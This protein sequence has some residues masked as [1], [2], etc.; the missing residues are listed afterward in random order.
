MTAHPALSQATRRAVRGLWTPLPLSQQAM[1]VRVVLVVLLPAASG[2]L[3]GL[4]LELSAPAYTAL[5]ALC[6]AGGLTAGR[7]H[8]SA[9]RG[10]RRGALGGTLFGACLLL[11]H[12]LGAGRA[13][14]RLPRP[15]IGQIAVTTTIGAVLGAAGSASRKRTRRVAGAAAYREQDRSGR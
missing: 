10:A 12:H 15:E 7:E 14:V 4:L 11:G 5:T 9:L 6:I 2:L 3:C 13:Q 1:R 8:L